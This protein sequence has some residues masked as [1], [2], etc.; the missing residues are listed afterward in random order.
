MTIA[1]AHLGK[2][3]HAQTT[4]RAPRELSVHLARLRQ[5]LLARALLR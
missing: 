2:F 3:G 5:P 1:A 4:D